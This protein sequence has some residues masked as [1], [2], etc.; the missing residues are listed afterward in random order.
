MRWEI[1][2]VFFAMSQY[3]FQVVPILRQVEAEPYK[4]SCKEPERDGLFYGMDSPTG[5]TLPKD[6]FSHGMVSPTGWGLTWD[7]LFHGMVFPWNAN[8]LLGWTLHTGVTATVLICCQGA[9]KYPLKNPVGTTGHAITTTSSSSPGPHPQY[10]LAAI[11][12][13]LPLYYIC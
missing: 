1:R 13:N 9:R 11:S 10:I 8:P 6:G 4:K 12:C 7:C 2:G 5:R 3:L